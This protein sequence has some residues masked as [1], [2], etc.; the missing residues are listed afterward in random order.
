[1]SEHHTWDPERYLTY[2]DERGRAFVELV[3]RIDA[4]DPGAVVDLGC[5]PG[6]LTNLLAER[7]PDAAVT[8]LDSSAEMIAAARATTSSVTYDVADLRDWLAGPA[9]PVDV[10]VSN[11]TL[12]WVPGHLD[13]MPAL[14]A[15]VSPGG[16]LAFQVPG[17]FDEPSH[18]IR[19]EL[20]EQEAYAA[21]TAGV[22]VPSS[23]DA[24]TYLEALAALG[25]TVDAWETTY[26]HVLHGEDPVF[27]WVSGTGARP[28]L[29]ALPSGLREQFEAEFKARLRAAYP[30]HGHG[31]V[32]PFR[33]IFVVAR[34]PG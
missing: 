26:L 8:G 22:A 1:M 25:C 3:Q 9:E 27:A 10:L 31:V 18:T 30:D 21:H 19:T 4:Q 2:A 32:L 29:Q 5:G 28:T 14:V 23:H 16:W 24:A 34:V 7:W 12:Q 17:N 11:A 15:R 20:A 33:R 13:L 6:N